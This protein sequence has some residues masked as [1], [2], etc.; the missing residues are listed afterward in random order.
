MP[1]AYWRQMQD[2]AQLGPRHRQGFL[3]QQFD[4]GDRSVVREALHNRLVRRSP[5]QRDLYSDPQLQRSRDERGLNSRG[6]ASARPF[7]LRTNKVVPQRRLRWSGWR[8]HRLTVHCQ[9]TS[10]TTR[11]EAAHQ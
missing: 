10:P 6:L 11:S 2:Q 4:T 7:H 3:R 5:V 8:S 1:C 9:G